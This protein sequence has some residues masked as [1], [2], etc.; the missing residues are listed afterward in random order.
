MNLSYEL[1]GKVVNFTTRAPSLLGATF[2]RVK[3]L[4]IL[5]RDT[6]M[7]FRDVTSTHL[8]VYPTIHAADPTFP[9]NATDYMYIKI[10]YEDGRVDAL[11]WAWIDENS[12]VEVT[13]ASATVHVDNITLDDI[14]R[15]RNALLSI[16]IGSFNIT[17]P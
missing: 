2:N 13:S 9:A 8:N 3:I 14:P 12:V 4:A 1:I 16:G 7:N 15:I 5:D 17:T 10:Q 6:A 11:G